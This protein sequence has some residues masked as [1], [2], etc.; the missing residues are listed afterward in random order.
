[1]RK[2]KREK[3]KAVNVVIIPDKMAEI[4]ETMIELRIQSQKSFS[5]TTVRKFSNVGLAGIKLAELND[6]PELNADET[7]TIIGKSVIDSAT[8]AKSSLPMIVK[9]CL[10]R[11]DCQNSFR[12][13]F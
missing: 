2:R 11:F 5:T 12:A 9:R 8:V 3:L 10:L 1:M 4:D 13:C 7:V 6:P